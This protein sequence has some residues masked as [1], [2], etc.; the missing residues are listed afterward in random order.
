MFH[1]MFGISD[2]MNLFRRVILAVNPVCFC[3]CP[4]S[5][6][7]TKKKQVI[8]VS[9]T[10]GHMPNSACTSNHNGWIKFITWMWYI[11]RIS[12]TTDCVVTLLCFVVK[13]HLTLLEYHRNWCKLASMKHD[14]FTLF[15][16][17]V[18]VFFIDV[19]V[20]IVGF[21]CLFS[22]C[23]GVVSCLL[24]CRCCGLVLLRFKFVAGDVI[25]CLAHISQFQNFGAVTQVLVCV[26][27]RENWLWPTE[28]SKRKTFRIT[29]I[30]YCVYNGYKV[31]GNV[32]ILYD[33]AWLSILQ[34]SKDVRE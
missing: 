1:C 24:R 34:V 19:I 8:S 23:C 22:C 17:K 29:W 3:K 33:I 20:I 14:I 15:A 16:T 27:T 21:W 2:Q 18:Y 11:W 25:S 5:N 13:H 32:L 10:Y 28:N 31:H 26:H 30:C 6:N 12:T 9:I 4:Y 7:D